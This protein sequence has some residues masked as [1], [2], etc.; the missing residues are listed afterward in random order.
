MRRILLCLLITSLLIPPT[1]I[2][3]AESYDIILRN[4]LIV[5]GSGGK[6]YRADIAIRN[7]FIYRIGN[8]RDSK[9]SGKWDTVYYFQDNQ[10]VREERDSDGDGI[11]DLR[12]LYDQGQIAAQEAD[13][14]WAKSG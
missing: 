14:N 4:G 9:A 10:L 8:L 12:I 13:T 3:V 11:F 2:G 1:A 5:D 7:G 6:G